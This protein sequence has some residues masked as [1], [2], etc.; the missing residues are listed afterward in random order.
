[1]GNGAGAS[2]FYWGLVD[3]YSPRWLVFENSFFPAVDSPRRPI[4][5]SHTPS[6]THTAICGK[7]VRFGRRS[8]NLQGTQRAFPHARYIGACEKGRE[9]RRGELV[10]LTHPPARVLTRAHDTRKLERPMSG[11]CFPSEQRLEH[12]ISPHG[13]MQ[14]RPIAHRGREN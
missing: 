10:R 5:K 1:M 11:A 4:K 9:R 2:H 14:T 6:G 8:Q 12:S 7:S 3:F 13:F